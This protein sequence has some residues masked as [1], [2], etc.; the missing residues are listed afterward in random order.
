MLLNFEFLITHTVQYQR[1]SFYSLIPFIRM[2]VL[3][4]K[5]RLILYFSFWVYK[6]QTCGHCLLILF[7]RQTKL[8]IVIIF[9]YTNWLLL[10]TFYATQ[11][12]PVSVLHFILMGRWQMTGVFL[13]SYFTCLYIIINVHHF[14]CTFS[15]P[16][17]SNDTSIF[18]HNI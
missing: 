3:W 4:E 7:K 17:L 16:Y 5:K 8:T 9:N 6:L 10:F 11:L 1:L 2:N 14:L 18:P 15:L 13:F 12:R